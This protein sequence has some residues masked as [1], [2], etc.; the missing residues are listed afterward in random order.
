MSP[1]ELN[2]HIHKYC[3]LRGRGSLKCDITVRLTPSMWDHLS[4]YARDIH[5][6]QSAVL[7]LA[8][9]EYLER[10]GRNALIPPVYH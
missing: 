1:D 9:F 10:Q 5:S 2:K 8:L 4:D 7:R 3:S 6:N